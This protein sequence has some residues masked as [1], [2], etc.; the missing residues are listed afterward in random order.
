[1]VVPGTKLVPVE[2]AVGTLER[3]LEGW[4]LCVPIVATADVHRERL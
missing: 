4:A 2:A 1:M 3:A